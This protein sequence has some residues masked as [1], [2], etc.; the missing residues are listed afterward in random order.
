MK[1]VVY[2]LCKNGIVSDNP[3]GNVGATKLG[4]AMAA[5]SYLQALSISRLSGTICSSVV[6]VMKAVLKQVVR[7]RLMG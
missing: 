1:Y 5:N 7:S 4:E 3:I 2:P 6:L